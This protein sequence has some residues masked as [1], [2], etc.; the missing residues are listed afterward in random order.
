MT[1]SL[2]E[3]HIV[4]KGEDEVV[5][6]CTANFKAEV[7]K[8]DLSRWL[9]KW[10]KLNGL[11]T[12]IINTSKEKYTGSTDTQLVI[13]SVCKE[14]EGKYQAVILQESKGIENRLS[15]NIICLHVVEGI[16][17]LKLYLL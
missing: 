16:L 2:E 17:F 7:K 15:S 3:P 5:C 10:Q 4:I 1:I 12:E 8:I 14:D 13:Q 11:I 9:I 6:G